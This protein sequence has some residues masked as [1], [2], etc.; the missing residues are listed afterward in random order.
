[1]PPK[2]DWVLCRVFH[3]SKGENSSKLSPP[4]MFETSTHAPSLTD[5]TMACAYQQISSL[6]TTP[7]HQSHGQSLLNLLQYSQEKINNNPAN[8]VSSKVDD[9]YEF[10]WDM[11]MEENSLGDHGV[12]SN[13]EDMRF[14]IDNSMVFL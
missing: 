6:S 8:E 12:A 2:E 14:E 10:L 13:M 1:M 5:Q 11:N 9:E 7:T 4:M 3:K